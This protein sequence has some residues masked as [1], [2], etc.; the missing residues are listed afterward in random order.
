MGVMY[1]SF[2]A[3][4]SPRTFWYIAMGSLFVVYF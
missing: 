3:T 1:M 2:G 4:V